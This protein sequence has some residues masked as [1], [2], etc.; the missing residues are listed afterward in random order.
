VSLGA[1]S[2]RLEG[3]D[4]V[5]DVCLCAEDKERSRGYFSRKYNRLK[6]RFFPAGRF[7]IGICPFAILWSAIGVLLKLMLSEI[8]GRKKLMPRFACVSFS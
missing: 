7:H 1:C 5:K 8:S 3:V 4:S 2:V 6:V